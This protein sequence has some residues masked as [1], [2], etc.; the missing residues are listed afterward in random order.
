MPMDRRTP[1]PAH[2]RTHRCRQKL[3]RLRPGPKGLFGRL[4]GLLYRGC[5]PHA[6]KVVAARGD[7]SYQKMIVASSKTN[8]LILGD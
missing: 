5:S 7:G 3:S 8:L 6:R 2:Q 4:L 1:Q